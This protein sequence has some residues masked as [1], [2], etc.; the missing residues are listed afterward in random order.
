[1]IRA[2]VVVQDAA[3]RRDHRIDRGRI[4]R[5]AP[6]QG[7]IRLFERDG[8]VLTIEVAPTA[9]IEV[10]G[11]PASLYA[12][13]R[14]MRVTV[15]RTG[16][17][18]AELV[19]QGWA[20]PAAL[21]NAFFGPALVRAEVVLLDAGGLRDYRID[22]GRLQTV[23]P[24]AGTIRLLERDGTLVVVSVAPS[25]Q[26]TLDGQR[27]PLAALRRGMRATVVRDGDRAAE[28]VEATR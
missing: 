5:V 22:R 9:T 10:R 17:R 7:T 1:M 23:A 12:L 27:V 26:V 16:D 14:G 4:L 25:A 20:V 8:T 2:E 13:R 24:R 15:V 19:R 18:P 21:R 3:G 28:L 6:R 11:L